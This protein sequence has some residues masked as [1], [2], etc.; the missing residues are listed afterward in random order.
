ME[1]NIKLNLEENGKGSFLIEKDGQ[2]LAEM[3]IGISGNN[4]T[5]YHTEVSGKLRGQGIAAQLV[6]EMVRYASEKDLK[7]IP[8]CAYVLAQ[9]KRQPEK[10]ADIWNQTW[11]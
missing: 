10:Y 5:V 1:N 11:H 8:L 9:F 7:V 4:L 6:S 2:P 3:V